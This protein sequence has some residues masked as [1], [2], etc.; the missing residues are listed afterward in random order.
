MTEPLGCDPTDPREPERHTLETEFE[1][2]RGVSEVVARHGFA[3]VHVTGLTGNIVEGRLR[4]LRAVADAE[5]SIDFLKLTPSGLSFLVSEDRASDIGKAL[6]GTGAEC[7]VQTGRSI[8]L[9]HAVNMRDE[10]GLIARIV[11]QAIAT[12]TSV[13]H[14]GDMHDRLLL[15]VATE[16]S[17]SLVPSLQKR[18][19]EN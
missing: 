1:K 6:T 2:R 7:S 13:E 9:V 10:E 15:V 19:A 3:Q 17:K 5:V 4:L 14:V 8:V 16:A 12:G 18:L 11:E